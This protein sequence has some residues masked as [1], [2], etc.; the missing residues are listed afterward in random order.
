[1][2]IWNA[3]LGE[4]LRTDGDPSIVAVAT[5]NPAGVTPLVG[6]PVF[7]RNDVDSIAAFIVSHCG[8]DTGRK[9]RA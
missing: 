1:L 4:P 8:L 6:V 9:V 2:E 7:D 5:D 3:A